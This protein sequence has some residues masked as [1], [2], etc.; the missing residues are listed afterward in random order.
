MMASGP[1]P[2]D[3]QDQ[4]MLRLPDG[5]RDRIKAA[6]EASN[7]SMNAEIVARLQ[8]SFDVMEHAEI[9]T[10]ADVSLWMV[11]D[12]KGMPISW[13]E[14]IT[15]I[16]EAIRAAGGRDVAAH[17]AVVDAKIEGNDTRMP[18]LNQLVRRYRTLRQTITGP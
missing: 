15:H 1:Y 6:A 18:A 5:M 16:T 7:R 8:G 17:V 2:S 11:L 9:D 13:S 10:G 3:R 4:F 12:A 14:I